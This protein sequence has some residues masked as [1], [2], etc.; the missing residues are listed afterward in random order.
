MESWLSRQC[1]KNVVYFLIS[2]AH[3]QMLGAAVF[4]VVFWQGQRGT[5][6]DAQDVK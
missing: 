1:H 3:K 2:I 6:R 5:K 4:F